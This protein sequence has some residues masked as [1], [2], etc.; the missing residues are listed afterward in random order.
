ML[1]PLLTKVFHAVGAHY[2]ITDVEAVKEAV[3]GTLVAGKEGK[4]FLEG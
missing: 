1:P 2:S 3:R 4:L